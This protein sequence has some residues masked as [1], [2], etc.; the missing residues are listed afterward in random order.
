MTERMLA[1]IGKTMCLFTLISLFMP[2]QAHAQ[3]DEIDKAISNAQKAIDAYQDRIIQENIEVNKAGMDRVPEVP[4]PLAG[5][6]GAGPRAYAKQSLDGVVGGDISNKQTL[7]NLGDDQKKSLKV[8]LDSWK[9]EVVTDSNALRQARNT[10]ATLKKQAANPN[11]THGQ[12]E[13]LDNALAMQQEKVDELFN[14]LERQTTIL[15]TGLNYVGTSLS[16][17]SGSQNAFNGEWKT[18]WGSIMITVA[19]DGSARGDYSYRNAN[20]HVVTGS[21]KGMVNDTVFNVSEWTEQYKDEKASGKATL[22]L[23]ADGKHF[24]GPWST[25]Q[26]ETYV[27]S[28]IWKGDK[29]SGE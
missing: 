7:D 23:S 28:G 13:A 27:K 20:K 2:Y 15:A 29:V 14:K 21:L 24:S 22:T 3:F 19:N 12:Q 16:K 10:L 25:L 18:S 17:K 5:N 6:I 8:V 11:N 1:R 26:G 4:A 9:D